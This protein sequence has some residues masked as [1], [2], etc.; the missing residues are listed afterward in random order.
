[1]ASEE[2]SKSDSEKNA[3]LDH[4]LIFP[5]FRK[6]TLLAVAFLIIVGAGVYALVTKENPFAQ[7]VSL[8]KEKN[9]RGAVVAVVNG[10]KIY[11]NM[12]DARVF[13]ARLSLES[14]GAD[15]DSQSAQEEIRADALE[16]LVGQR[17]LLQDAAK[18][19]FSAS[20]E[21]VKEEYQKMV[22]QF[23]G[24]EKLRER[25][26]ATR[27]TDKDLRQN[28]KEQIIFIRYVEAETREEAQVTNEEIETLYAAY[29]AQVVDAPELD[30]TIR[31]TVEKEIR[32]RKILQIIATRVAELKK[33]ADIKIL[34]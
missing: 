25:L 19:K 13:Q 2:Q 34:I 15:F 8:L 20:R 9:P 31:R 22:D 27:F 23:G 7:F 11:Q 18:K 16:M 4:K 33:G 24:E 28:L 26:L 32:D 29:K 30:D 1:M 5:R 10:E 17:L 14:N 12:L 6:T 3:P 21:D